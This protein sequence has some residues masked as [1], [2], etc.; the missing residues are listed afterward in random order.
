LQIFPDVTICN[1]NP[2]S[3]VEDDVW[4]KFSKDIASQWTVSC[5]SANNSSDSNTTSSGCS[6]AADDLSSSS[7]MI[8][9]LP[10]NDTKPQRE[11]IVD[12]SL[13]NWNWGSMTDVRCTDNIV[14]K[15]NPSYYKC[16]TISVPEQF[17]Q[18]TASN[19]DQESRGLG[20]IAPML[21]NLTVC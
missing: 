12:C 18:V 14:V 9:S 16:F 6:D 21:V 7:G 20:R 19:C 15:W 10:V 5:D 1:L 8:L 3:V 17:K 4:N 11:L 13:Y 2:L